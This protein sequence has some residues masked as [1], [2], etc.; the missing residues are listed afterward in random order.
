MEPSRERVEDFMRRYGYVE[1]EAEAAI[2]LREAWD[3]LTELEQADAEAANISQHALTHQRSLV[4]QHFHALGGV[5][6]RRVLARQF[7]EGWGFRPAPEEEGPP[8]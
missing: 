4:D 5:L 3:R 7:P 8:E 6:A 2:Y 1:K